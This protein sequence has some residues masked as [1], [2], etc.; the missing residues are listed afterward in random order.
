M[1]LLRLRNLSYNSI[2]VGFVSLLA[3]SGN[4]ETPAARYQDAQQGYAFTPPAGWE[5]KA[6]LPKPLVAFVGPPEQD[7]APNF[8]VNVYSRL[9]RKTE[10]AAFLESVQKEYK[11][12]GKMS[13]IQKTKLAGQ[14]AYTWSAR[15]SV[16]NFPTVVNRQIVCFV[17]NRAYELTFTA[18]PATMKKQEAVFAKIT[19]SFRFFKPTQAKPEK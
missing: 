18:L 10:E 8:S 2:V 17:N 11:K 1:K 7:Y 14:P 15:L 4:A 3:Q 9:V 12:H 16:P 13:A 19:A 6:D 5:R